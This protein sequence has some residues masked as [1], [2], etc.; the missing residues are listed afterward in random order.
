[1]V[2]AALL[3]IAGAPKLSAPPPPRALL[4]PWTSRPL[5]VVELVVGSWALLAPEAGGAWAAAVLYTGLSG[6][7]G[8]ALARHEPDCGCFGAT[9]VRPDVRHL[10]V[11]L[12]FAGAAILAALQGWTLPEPWPVAATS[13]ALA[14]LAAWGVMRWLTP[15]QPSNHGGS[16]SREHPEHL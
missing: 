1:M 3:V 15:A 14:L 16:R 8:W 4:P 9:P 2:G 10:S 6:T 7:M 11:N 13:V 5:G 12:V